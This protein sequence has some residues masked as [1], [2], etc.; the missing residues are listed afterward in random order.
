VLIRKCV[1]RTFFWYKFSYED[2]VMDRLVF[3]DGMFPVI[4]DYGFAYSK[5]SDNTSYNNSLF[6]TDKGYTPFA[7]DEVND[8]KTLLVRLAYVQNCPSDIT[9]LADKHFLNSTALAFKIKRETGWISTTVPSIS[10]IISDRVVKYLENSSIEADTKFLV[11]TID[12]VVELFGILIKLP[13]ESNDLCRTD[14]SLKKATRDFVEEW[15]KIEQWFT[16][17]DDK[18]N[19]LK[20]TFETINA[21]IE[22]TDDFND[23]LYHEF[24]IRM[25]QVFDDFGDFVDVQNVDYGKFMASILR[26]SGYIERVCFEQIRSRQKMFGYPASMT[27]WSLFKDLERAVGSVDKHT[28]AVNDSIVLFDCV[29]QLVSS[30][31]LKSEVVASLNNEHD[32]QSQLELLNTFD[33]EDYH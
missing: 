5:G 14:D 33:F 21:I 17:V 24:K 2:V 22:E 12:E 29:D 23:D 19:V 28:F 30:F 10:A 31:D 6:F 8:F 18:L 25:F 16:C 11:H 7:F 4:F 27:G 13:F 26:V 3:T 9:E 1:K 32:A 20:Q 15:S